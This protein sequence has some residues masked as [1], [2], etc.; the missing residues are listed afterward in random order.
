MIVISTV[1]GMKI[2]F[3]T[4][5]FIALALGVI[6]IVLPL[7]PTT[8]FL[9]LAAA[10][11]LRGSDRMYHWLTRN[12]VFGHYLLDYQKHRGVTLRV[13][14]VAI[15]V[16]WTSLLYAMYLMP[17]LRWPLGIIGT[18]V[19]LYL[20]LRLKTISSSPENH[21]REIDENSRG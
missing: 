14:I 21:S 4:V 16:M 13:K 3:N 18:G 11:F 5:G 2:L 1:P 9:L 7:L 15:S 8:P 12:P 19:T 10:C 17:A 20:V 6:G